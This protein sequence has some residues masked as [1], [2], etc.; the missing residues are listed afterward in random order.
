MDFKLL[1]DLIFQAAGYE[2]RAEVVALL[3]Y[4]GADCNHVKNSYG[5][6]ARQEVCNQFVVK[7]NDR[8]CLLLAISLNPCFAF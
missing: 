7:L 8:V 6:S 4:A 2:S 5:M 3:L 1:L